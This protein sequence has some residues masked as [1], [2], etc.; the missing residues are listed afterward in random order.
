MEEPDE[1]KDECSPQGTEQKGDIAF[2]VIFA[3]GIIPPARL[4]NRVKRYPDEQFKKR[5]HK[6]GTDGEKKQIIS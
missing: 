6:E 1:D 4:E 3:I 2:I 5:G